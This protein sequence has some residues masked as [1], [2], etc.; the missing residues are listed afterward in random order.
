[1]LFQRNTELN[2]N[3]DNTSYATAWTLAL[4]IIL[5]VD[6]ARH[7]MCLTRSH[8]DYHVGKQTT[9]S[10]AGNMYIVNVWKTQLSLF[11]A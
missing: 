3:T 2:Y 6:H 7:A 1:M 8:S 5:H 9:S 4:T 10:L 11:A